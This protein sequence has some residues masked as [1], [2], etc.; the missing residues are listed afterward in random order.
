[1]AREARGEVGRD[2]MQHDPGMSIRQAALPIRLLQMSR[3]RRDDVSDLHDYACCPAVKT[4]THLACS[5]NRN[6]SDGWQHKLVQK[7]P[8]PTDRW[9]MRV[10]ALHGYRDPA[11][12]ERSTNSCCEAQLPIVDKLANQRAGGDC[13]GLK[14][15]D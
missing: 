8:F 1:M 5:R 11:L 7:F 14:A 15:R 9:M 12:G 13:G 4:E 6:S 2:S 10:L 3:Y